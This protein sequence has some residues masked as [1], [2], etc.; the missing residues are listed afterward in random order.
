MDLGGGV[1]QIE[2]TVVHR[3]RDGMGVRLDISGARVK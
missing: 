2:G 1:V 3:S